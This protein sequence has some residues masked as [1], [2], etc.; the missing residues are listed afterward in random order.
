MDH[1]FAAGN[2]ADDRRANFSTGFTLRGG[3]QLGAAV[4]VES[5]GYPARLYATYWVERVRGAVVDTI[6]FTGTPRLPNLDYG[7][8]VPTP[9]F[10]SFSLSAF[11]FGG[12]DDTF[13]EWANGHIL[14]GN[15]DLAWRPT[16]QLRAELIYDH[17]QV[18]RPDDG[19]SVSLI[20]V[21]P[22]K[23]EYQLS[24][25]IFLRLIGQYTANQTDALRDDSRTGGAILIRDPVPGA[26]TR[27]GPTASNAFR[28][29]WL[30][31]YHPTSGTVGYLGY[32]N[33][34]LEPAPFR[35][36]GLSRVGDGFFAKVSYPFRF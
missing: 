2:P 6:P 23:V 21:P 24:A 1:H 17:Q 20:R 35:F 13:L 26:F 30:F 12:R 14:I 10:R 3:W 28:I 27:T 25:P 19:S 15:G 7:V 5:F 29:D 31:S 33:S 34:L 4:S 16:R 32:G 36:R 11:L 8:N 9:N 22:L 18:V